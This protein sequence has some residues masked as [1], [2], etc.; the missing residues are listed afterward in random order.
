MKNSPASVAE[1][2]SRLAE[3]VGCPFDQL[4]PRVVIGAM[5]VNK[6]GAGR[7]VEHLLSMSPSGRGRDFP[8]GELKTYR[9]DADGFPHESVAILQFGPR[10]DEFL[11]CPRFETTVLYRRLARLL[12]VGIFKDGDPGGWRVQT[13]FRLDL[14]VGSEW[15]QRVEAS[16]REVLRALFDRLRRGESISTV[17]APFLQIRVHDAKPYRPVFSARLG[18]EV[19]NKQLGFY[20]PRAAVAEMVNEYTATEIG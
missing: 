4:L 7:A 11:S 5:T 14:A 15:Y 18:R 3:L 9:S 2:H 6:G 16:Y 10:F 17:S 19:A 1:A 8:D 12:L 13:V 20:L